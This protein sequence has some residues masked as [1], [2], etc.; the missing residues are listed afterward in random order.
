MIAKKRIRNSHGSGLAEFGP[1]LFLFFAVVFFPVINLLGFAFGVATA[2]LIADRC[3]VAA[4]DEQ[5]YSDALD[6]ACSTAVQLNNSPFGRFAGLKPV[7][8]FKGS[9]VDLYVA[10]TN[11]SSKQTKVCGPDVPIKEKIDTT[12]NVYEYEAQVNYAIGPVLSMGHLP[13]IKD[14]PIIGKAGSFS[15]TVQKAAEHPD[16][17][18]SVNTVQ[19]ANIVQTY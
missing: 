9:G 10:T 14:I 6:A 12:G 13:F 5:T 11:V 4:A 2:E 15:Y 19:E 1:A 18:S 3:A 8:G 7:N 16:G 17:L